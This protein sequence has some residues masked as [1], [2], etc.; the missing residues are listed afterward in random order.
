MPPPLSPTWMVG[1]GNFHPQS[2]PCT[3][4][5]LNDHTLE[6]Y[7]NNYKSGPP[8]AVEQTNFSTE[9][10]KTKTKIISITN[11]SKENIIVSQ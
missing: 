7:Q 8:W 6:Y 9:F 2:C 1:H 11:Q 4:G 3:S 5:N 10:Q